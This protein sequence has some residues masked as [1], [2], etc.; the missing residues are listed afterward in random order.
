MTPKTRCVHRWTG[1]LSRPYRYPRSNDARIAGRLKRARI[2]ANSMY[3]PQQ[4]VGRARSP[5]Q[6]HRHRGH[7]SRRPQKHGGRANKLDYTFATS[8]PTSF[9]W[10]LM[11]TFAPSTKANPAQGKLYRQAASRQGGRIG[12][13]FKLGYNTRVDGARVLDV[14]GKEVTPIWQLRHWHRGILTAALS[15]E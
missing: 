10:T 1:R 15:S 8:P 5:S 9:S 3:L 2:K 14:N 4:C 13:I 12:H 6:N 11:A 7:S